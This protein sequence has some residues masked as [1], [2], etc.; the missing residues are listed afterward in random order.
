MMAICK[1]MF[2]NVKTTEWSVVIKGEEE[3]I[4]LDWVDGGVRKI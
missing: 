1:N 2:Q 3:I 4:V